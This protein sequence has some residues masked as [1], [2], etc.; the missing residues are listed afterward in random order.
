MSNNEEIVKRA[1]ALL[2]RADELRAEA[3][4]VLDPLNE[5]RGWRGASDVLSHLM[6]FDLP[7]R[8]DL[9]RLKTFRRTELLK[10]AQELEF[11]GDLIEAVPGPTKTARRSR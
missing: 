6:N 4:E 10:A 7:R 2:A 3:R 1:A 8:P 9:P 5:A 11:Q